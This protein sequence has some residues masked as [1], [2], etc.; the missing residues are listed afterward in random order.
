MKTRNMKSLNYLLA[1]LLIG[2]VSTSLQAQSCVGEPGTIE[3]LIFRKIGN[4][5]ELG[6]LNHLP[7]Y[8]TQPDRVEY[9]GSAS[10]TTRYDDD[11]GGL[12]RGYIIAPETGTYLFNMTAD[13]NADL[14]L[15]T[16]ST[17]TNLT[18]IAFIPGYSNELEFNKY[19][20]QTS[21]SI[22]LVAGKPYY[23]EAIYKEGGGGDFIRVHWRKPSN[24]S[25]P[26]Y[27]QIIP[28]ANLARQTCQ[29]IC[30]KKNTSCDD[31]NPSTTDDRYDA[32]CNCLG[33][34]VNAPAC[35]G[36][37]GSV[38]ALYWDNITG[39]SLTNLTSN[40]AY[41]LMPSRGAIMN[42]L[43]VLAHNKDNFGTRLR[44]Y[45]QVPVTGSYQF[46]VTGDNSVRLM[47]GTNLAG[48]SAPVIAYN[49][50]SSNIFDHYKEPQMTSA[51]M[52]LSA[53]S[54]YYIEFLHKENTGGD[55]F[56]VFWRTPFA[57]DTVWRIVDGAYLYQFGCE[58]ACIPENT[59][60]DDG[61]PLT[62]NDKYNNQ[63]ACVGTPCAD[64]SC[65]ETLGYTPNDACGAT[66]KHSNT[67]KDA[68]TSC[69]PTQSP[70]PNRDI[71]HWI[72]Y[73]LGQVYALD[74][75][76]VW[77]YNAAGATNQG[78]EHVAV[79]YSLDGITWFTLGDYTWDQAPGTNGYAGFQFPALEG[80]VA[81]FVLLTALDNFDN[82]GCVGLSEVVINAVSCDEV[83]FAC[84][85]AD[86]TTTG[87]TYGYD[88][89][90]RGISTAANACDVLELITS[91][92]FLQDGQY[93]AMLNL[94]SNGKIAT[95]DK[96]RFIAS[97]SIKLTDGFR[98]AREAHFI[99]KLGACDTTQVN[100]LI[101]ANNAQ[102]QA[103]LGLTI[104]P[105]KISL[106][107][108][109]NPTR[110]WAKVQYNIP[111]EGNMRLGIFDVSGQVIVWL[112]DGDAPAGSGYK[113]FPAHQLAA[114]L[115]FVVLQFDGQTKTER[116]VVLD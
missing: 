22:S 9:V 110:H 8:P 97:Q 39:S 104:E 20:S 50:N 71:S 111:Q 56:G 16:D 73:D 61:D 87:D 72:K 52:T 23:F 60:C 15:S 7:Q 95:G 67:P 41:P 100:S 3:W 92:G 66:D 107:I 78:F 74:G 93:D 48:T 98:A 44:G 17:K 5:T 77:N 12:I 36:D 26:N 76:Q 115:Y 33:T 37:R 28:G 64:P 85:D 116:L 68:W 51:V 58:L 1:W 57:A 13:D 38:R 103:A 55:Q 2:I 94:T 84:D 88:C 86:P 82:S 34:P 114:G 91:S 83:G 99:A 27:W 109:P 32:A 105:D 113:S 54:L 53:D 31:G 69:Q 80:M 25:D 101:Q 10:T 70:N 19:T 108:A 65:S 21:V 102:T 106:S 81:R 47:L 42:S 46:N 79:D 11:F 96:V 45:L 29:P 35:L 75:S 90:C 49:I 6:Y 18:R 4:K 62:Y 24:S 112:N 43:Y 59:P 40:P 63:C 89:I 14:Y 30:P